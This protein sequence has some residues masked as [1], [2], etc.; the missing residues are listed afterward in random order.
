MPLVA[1]DT[2]GVF[3]PMIPLLEHGNHL[4]DFGNVLDHEFS[5]SI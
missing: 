5:G 2:I 4:V 3:N 1:I